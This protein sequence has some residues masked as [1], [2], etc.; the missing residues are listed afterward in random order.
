MLIYWIDLGIIILMIT[1]SLA[2]E[3]YYGVVVLLILLT[4]VLYLLAFMIYC[5][6]TKKYCALLVLIL[7]CLLGINYYG[8]Y[9]FEKENPDIIQ[10]HNSLHLINAKATDH[11]K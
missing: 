2:V 9:I 11:D 6:K 4:I 3:F 8:K 5:D 10:H 7:I 1:L